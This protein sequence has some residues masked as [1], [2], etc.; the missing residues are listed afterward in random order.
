MPS[1]IWMQTPN[2]DEVMGPR[3]EWNDALAAFLRKFGVAFP[4]LA[5]VL[6]AK[7]RL[8]LGTF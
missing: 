7:I 6:R 4:V 2:E 8:A 3:T 1:A 5:I